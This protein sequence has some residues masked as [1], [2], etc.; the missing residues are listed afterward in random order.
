MAV[1]VHAIFGILASTWGIVLESGVYLMLGFLFAGLLG[2]FFREET[3]ARHLGGNR[4]RSVVNASLVGIPLPL[5]SCGVISA[6]TGLRKQGAGRAATLS[7]LTSTP[8][9]GVDSIFISYA[10]LGPL[11]TAVR[12]VSA[13]VT[14]MLAGLAEVLFGHD[15]TERHEAERSR[16]TP[17]FRPNL[18][19]RLRTGLRATFFSVVGDI[20]TPHWKGLLIAGVI[21]YF[22]EPGLVQRYL[23]GEWYA[24][25]MALVAGLPL[26][27][28]ATASTPIVAALLAAGMS[29]GA[30][31]VFLLAGPATNASTMTVVGH[32]L[33]RR[34]LAMYLGSI[35]VCSLLLGWGTN[36]LLGST[37]WTAGAAVHVGGAHHNVLQWIGGLAFVTWSL[38]LYSRRWMK[39][40]AR[41]AEARREEV[42]VPAD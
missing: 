3:I 16:N 27:I 9:T 1:F 7:F 10:L 20:L 24:M 13:F 4:L 31:V 6:T 8:Q 23:G 18:K 28:C 39:R 34:S 37:G 30:A 38:R 25:P 11:L 40:R 42:E 32:Q 19:T 12:V 33:G 22:V 2:A 26:Y 17:A 35:V 29:P 15:R 14:A 41:R 21:G 36:L 5:C